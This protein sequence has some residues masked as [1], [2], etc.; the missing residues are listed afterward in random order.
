[1]F[2]RAPTGSFL[3]GIS[4]EISQRDF[5]TLKSALMGG[6]NR[7]LARFYTLCYGVQAPLAGASPQSENGGLIHVH[8][9]RRSERLTL[10]GGRRTRDLYVGCHALGPAL[11]RSFIMV[12]T[13]PRGSCRHTR[14][15]SGR[16]SWC[17]LPPRELPTH[18]RS[19]GTKVHGW[20]PCP[21]LT[22]WRWFGRMKWCSALSSASATPWSL[23]DGF[24]EV[25]V[26]W[27]SGR[28]GQGQGRRAR[29]GMPQCPHNAQ[30]TM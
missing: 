30:P 21:H 18:N 26:G 27:T 1:M 12:L 14:R 23:R 17:S 2:R 6:R 25:V 15:L 24:V 3:C 9:D 16:L 8:I 20:T 4:A 29:G 7:F 22:P 19:G 28:R 13:P 11:V 5:C 10:R